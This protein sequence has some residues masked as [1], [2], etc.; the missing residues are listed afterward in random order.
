[1]P[2]HFVFSLNVF[3]TAS[4]FGNRVL[5][6]LF[7]LQLDASPAQIGVLGA[8]F[9]VF[10]SLL[11]VA[12]GRMADRYGSRY[13]LML[14]TAGT[15]AGML[16]PYFFPSLTAIMIAALMCGFSQVFFNVSTQN[17]TGLL[18]TPDNRA[19][20]FSNYALTNSLGQFM[21]PLMGGFAIGHFTNTTASFLMGMFAFIPLLMLAFRRTPLEAGIVKIVNKKKDDKSGKGAS[22]DGADK[23]A[24]VPGGAWA[25]LKDPNVRRTLYTGSLLNAGLNLYQ[26]YMPV[27]A[28]S[29]GMSASLIG[30]IM[31]AHSAAAFVVRVVLPSLIKRLNED[32]VLIMSFSVGAV[33]LMLMPVF[34]NAWMLGFLSFVFGL[35]MGAGQPIV[36]MQMFMNSA[37][38]R[39]GEGIGLKMTTNQITKIISPLAFGAIASAFGLLAMFWMNAVLMGTG[40][41]LARV[42]GKPRKSDSGAS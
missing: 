41:Y 20:N 22:N 25:M 30:I 26:F 19:R 18:S 39:S 17:L 42:R 27:Y 24:P 21:G 6:A 7:A 3:N 15:G 2:I 16:L 14:G 31:A 4:N 10:P 35:G 29:V 12:A 38:G 5:L 1:M 34:S 40:G 36:T 32:R 37:E 13:L 33:S 8:M 9:A 23:A 11:A 28:V